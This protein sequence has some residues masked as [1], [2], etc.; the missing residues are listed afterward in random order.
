MSS[1]HIKE[2]P[3]SNRLIRFLLITLL[4]TWMAS[5]AAQSWPS[6]PITLVA[7]SSPG[8][9]PDTVAR[10]LAQKLGE[11]LG[12]PVVVQNR[13]GASG[14][15]G[16]ELVANAPPDGYT[17]LLGSITN[18]VNP[19]MT[20][21]L[22]FTLDD[23]APVSSVAA[24]PDI[25]TVNPAVPVS[26]V[27]ELIGWLRSKPGTAVAIPGFGSTPH[28]SAVILQSMTGIKLNIVPYSGGGAVL[29]GLLGNQVP[30][31]FVTSLAV[32]PQLRANQ[33]RGLGVTSAKRLASMPELPTLAEQGLPGFDVVAW[34]G[35][36]APAKTPK[37][38]IDRLSD[39]TRKAL[40]SA[41]VRK[42]LN[43][44]GADSLGSSPE[45]FGTFV[46]AEYSRWGKVV[47]ENGIKAE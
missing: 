33:L 43:D 12:Q 30:A 10:I 25:L 3:M 46:K 4:S 42:R 5:A 7:P 21:G 32:I 24:A 29:Q 34:F 13:A 11:Q 45:D 19:H 17:L 44:L 9:T 6:R 36:F 27:Q 22:R 38:I 26:N 31:A 35:V 14:N 41:E 1:H 37:A 18:T 23:L 8:S 15:I 16:S 20:K 40:A 39:E 47:T 28:L 2:V